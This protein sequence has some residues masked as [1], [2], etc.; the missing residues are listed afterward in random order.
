MHSVCRTFSRVCASRLP[1]HIPLTAKPMQYLDAS[2]C[3]A[4]LLCFARFRPSTRS[5]TRRSCAST[6]S[7][8]WSCRLTCTALTTRESRPPWGT[9]P[10]WSACWRS[11]CRSPSGT[12]LSTMPRGVPE[13]EAGGGRRLGTCCTA[14]VD[15]I[16]SFWALTMLSDLGLDYRPERKKYTACI[17]MAPDRNLFLNLIS[18][19]VPFGK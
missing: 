6:P 4:P 9:R 11:T 5:S 1:R 17:L 2:R 7:E 19:A 8:A 18:S 14:L 15:D 3:L 12:S 16:R 10:T 13:L